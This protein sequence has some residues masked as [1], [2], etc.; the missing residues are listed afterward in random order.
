MGPIP[1]TLCPL[2]SGTGNAF[3]SIMTNISFTLHIETSTGETVRI[4]AGFQYFA[5]AE[6]TG[7]ALTAETD[8]YYRILAEPLSDNSTYRV[9]VQV[10]EHASDRWQKR[11]FSSEDEALEW[12]TEFVRE[13]AEDSEARIGDTIHVWRVGD[14]VEVSRWTPASHY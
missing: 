1:E 11:A 9:T 3:I 12:A 14:E 13:G 7:D 10:R 8:L 4:I 6:G 2:I 5:V